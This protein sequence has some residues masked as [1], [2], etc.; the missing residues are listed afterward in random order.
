[1]HSAFCFQIHV[2]SFFDSI[3]SAKMYFLPIHHNGSDVLSNV[4]MNAKHPGS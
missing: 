1:M 3:E 4:P 2:V